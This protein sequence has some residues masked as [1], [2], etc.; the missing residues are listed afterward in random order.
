[1]DRIKVGIDIDDVLCDFS[2]PFLD[3]ARDMFGRPPK[4]AVA[5]DWDYSGDGLSAEEL[6]KVWA[7]VESIP[8]YYTTLPKVEPAEFLLDFFDPKFIVYFVTARRP[9]TEGD[10]IEMQTAQWLFEHYSCFFPTVIVNKDK[11]AIVEA[12]G[13]EYFIDDKPQN[14][15]NIWERTGIKCYLMN[16]SHNE[17]FRDETFERVKS[18]RKFYE[19]LLVDQELRVKRGNPQKE[20]KI[21]SKES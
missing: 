16:H 11:A 17:W 5:K 14:L 12:L 20:I 15:L 9:K 1:L 8:N 21:V 4:G 18:I 19:K 2:G 7:K 13:I 3:L 10:P 6:A